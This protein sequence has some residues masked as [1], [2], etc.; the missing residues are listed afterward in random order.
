MV[1]DLARAIPSGTGKGSHLQF[2]GEELER[3]LEEGC[4]YLAERGLAMP[5]DLDTIEARGSLP[6]ADAA[7]VSDRARQR[8]GGQLGTIGSGNH[9][10]EVQRVDEIFDPTPPRSWACAPGSWSS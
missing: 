5:E 4:S 7:G 8:G 10:V 6:W 2:V 3:V 1:H 9:F